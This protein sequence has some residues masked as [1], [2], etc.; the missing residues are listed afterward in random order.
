MLNII[1]QLK[2][3]LS[4]KHMFVLVLTNSYIYF[5]LS[6]LCGSHLSPDYKTMERGLKYAYAMVVV[7]AN[8]IIICIK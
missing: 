1:N 2:A 3:R 5:L 8:F 4:S 6:G 7:S